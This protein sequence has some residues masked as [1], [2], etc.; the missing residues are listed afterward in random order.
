VPNTP[1]PK[2]C[3]VCGNGKTTSVLPTRL[4]FMEHD[5][6]VSTPLAY[7]CGKGHVFLFQELDGSTITEK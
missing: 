7:R 4:V 2:C 6:Q 5:E 3:P 1:L